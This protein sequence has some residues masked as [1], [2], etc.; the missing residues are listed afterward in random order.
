[1]PAPLRDAR[2]CLSEAG[3]QAFSTAPPGRAPAEL[4]AHVAAC[5]RCQDRVLAADAG[6]RA[7]SPRAQ[8]P[9]R[10][11][12]FVLFVAGLVMAVLLYAWTRRLFEPAP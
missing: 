3:L 1:M 6:T 4:A 12:I 11:R 5:P 9:P 8:P 7:A 2:G 10:W